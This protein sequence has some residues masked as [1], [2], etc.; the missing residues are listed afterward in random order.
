MACA[1]SF[2]GA[3]QGAWRQQSSKRGWSEIVLPVTSD[4]RK[5]LK[6]V[7]LLLA[8]TRPHREDEPARGLSPA[9]RHA[10]EL[11]KQEYRNLK[12]ERQEV[13]VTKPGTY[14][15]RTGERL[16]IRHEGK[17]EAEIP[18]SM[19]RNITL[20][21]KAV[22]LSGDLMSEASARGINIVLAG[23]DGRPLV[24]DWSAGDCRTSALAG[25]EHYRRLS[26]GFGI[27]PRSSSRARS[28]IRKIFCAIT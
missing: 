11:R 24:R 15:G 13:L 27:G 6:W 26:A 18:L 16:L 19:I 2:S 20:L 28:V 9:A 8:R 23:S 4:P 10:I 5:K 1:L 22:S 3:R 14:L 17:R 7:E 25:P 12:E 21:T